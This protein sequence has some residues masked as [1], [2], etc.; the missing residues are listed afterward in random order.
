MNTHITAHKA[1]VRHQCFFLILCFHL[2]CAGVPGPC[3]HSVTQDHLLN[4]KRLIKNQ[5]QNGCSITYTFT[6]RQN[7][8]VVC[9]VKAAFPHILELLNTQFSY[10][11]DS[12]NY[13]YTNSLKNLIYNIY[14]QRCI[15]PINEEIEDSPTK[16]IRIHMTLPRAALEKAEEVIRMY[17]G[18]MT[19][20]DKPVDWNCEEEYTEDYPE[21][22]TEPLSQT[23]GASECPCIC[24]TLSSGSSRTSTSTSHWNIYLKSTPSP[25]RSSFSPVVTLQGG[26][27]RTKQFKSAVPVAK[28]QT[29][30]PGTPTTWRSMQGHLP[31][32]LFGSNP[33]LPEET[34][35][36]VMQNMP[37][38]DLFP[39]F[40]NSKDVF[41]SRTDSTVQST[42][43]GPYQKNTRDNTQD[44]VERSTPLLLAKRSLD[45]KSQKGPSSSY[46]KLSQNRVTATSEPTYKDIKSTEIKGKSFQT[47]KHIV[48]VTTT[49]MSSLKAAAHSSGLSILVEQP[50]HLNSPPENFQTHTQSPVRMPRNFIGTIHEAKL[51]RDSKSQEDRKGMKDQTHPDRETQR[52]SATEESSSSSIIS[53]DTVLIITL[54]C[55]GLLL[56]TVLF[57][58][59]QKV[60][61]PQWIFALLKRPG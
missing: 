42:A 26:N 45:S 50:G 27:E 51:S 24:P 2:V 19:Q 55:G 16:F 9:Y 56:I 46:V 59:Q 6:E 44:S 52:N 58:R 33:A 43:S 18:L 7:L 30:A 47:S 11:K 34:S 38:S 25:Q 28:H 20:S 40:T 1:K 12:D 57:Y 8:S 53:F 5:L 17:M 14:S 37:S 15:P 48:P 4:L 39:S 35:N 13:R 54:G 10:A 21:S 36:S 3:K 22:T 60:S 32:F 23:A 49:V 41:P 29:L 61:D 31:N